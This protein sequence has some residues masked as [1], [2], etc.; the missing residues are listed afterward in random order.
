M[1]YLYQLQGV[2]R[3]YEDISLRE[4]VLDRYQ[5]DRGNAGYRACRN[6]LQARRPDNYRWGNLIKGLFGDPAEFHIT[7]SDGDQKPIDEVDLVEAAVMEGLDLNCDGEVSDTPGTMDVNY[8]SSYEV[9]ED[10]DDWSNLYLYYRYLNYQNGKFVINPG[11]RVRWARKPS[12]VTDEAD[13]AKLKNAP[14]EGI[15]EWVPP[16]EVFE[17]IHERQN[18][19]LAKQR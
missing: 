17:A 3:N 5:M 16:R 13:L 10:H 1:N 14:A 4:M 15:E 7:F 11:S 9:L 19:R 12:D 2:P 6:E 18:R 8:S